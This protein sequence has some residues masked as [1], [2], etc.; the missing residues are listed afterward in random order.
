[1]P[2]GPVAALNLVAAEF[3]LEPLVDL[4]FDRAIDIGAIDLAA[5]LVHDGATA[6]VYQGTAEAF[7]VNATTVRVP[8]SE[9][10]PWTGSGTHLIVSANNG[11]VAVDDGAQWAGVTDVELPFG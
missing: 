2:S 3:G 10:E 9:L 1:M 4:A 5:F 8:L 6:M 11:I 7:L